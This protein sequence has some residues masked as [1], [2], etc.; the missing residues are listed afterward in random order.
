MASSGPVGDG[1][2]ATASEKAVA[3]SWTEE[4]SR[5]S[6]RLLRGARGRFRPPAPGGGAGGALAQARRFACCPLSRLLV[7][8]QTTPV[9]RSS[10]SEVPRPAV[11]PFLSV[12]LLTRYN[13]PFER[14]ADLPPFPPHPPST[15]TS[16]CRLR[17]STTVPCEWPPRNL[18][19]A[20]QHSQQLGQQHLGGAGGLG[21]W[22]WDGRGRSASSRWG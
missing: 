20:S 7:P 4:A 22:C 19:P 21:W 16:K 11:R 8:P 9:R 14:P 15:L 17:T 13:L 6:E 10:P 1:E 5:P 12:R 18:R 3:M 2:V